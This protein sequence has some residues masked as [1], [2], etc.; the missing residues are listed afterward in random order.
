MGKKKKVVVL[1]QLKKTFRPFSY[2]TQTIIICTV[3]ASTAI[4]SVGN[5]HTQLIRLALLESL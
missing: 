1:G 2:Q 4:L 5:V 3:L